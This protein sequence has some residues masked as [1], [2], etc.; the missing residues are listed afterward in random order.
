MVWKISTMLC[1]CRLNSTLKESFQKRSDSKSARDRVNS[2]GEPIFDESAPEIRLFDEFIMQKM[3]RSVVTL[4]KE[5]SRF[6]SVNSHVCCRISLLALDM[7]SR[8]I[9]SLWYPLLI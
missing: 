1:L 6:V 8:V 7:Q 4:N 9:T 2:L 5:V 3:N